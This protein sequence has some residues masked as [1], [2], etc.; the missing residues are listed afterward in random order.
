MMLISVCR[1]ISCLFKNGV[2]LIACSV[3]F[4]SLQSQLFVP[5]RD[6]T[7]QKTVEAV[8][9]RQQTTTIAETQSQPSI[10][11]PSPRG[12]G[13]GFRQGCRYR[14]PKGF[15]RTQSPQSV[16]KGIENLLHFYKMD[17]FYNLM[18]L[19]PLWLSAAFLHKKR[20]HRKWDFFWRR[21]RDVNPRAGF[22][23]YSLSRGAPSPLG[24]FCMA[25]YK[26][27]NWCR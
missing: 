27:F 5:L 12:R 4:A 20:S 3:G 13:L 16:L 17:F 15:A 24:Y 7:T 18:L 1:K 11:S 26:I 8:T 22:P 2:S 10:H 9:H 23:T 21:K 19:K 14:T 25:N 6:A